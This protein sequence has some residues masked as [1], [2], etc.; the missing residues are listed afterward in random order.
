MTLTECAVA[1]GV[2]RY[3]LQMMSLILDQQDTSE[4]MNVPATA[5]NM[6]YYSKHDQ[7]S[8]AIKEGR[9]L[10][11]FLEQEKKFPPTYKYDPGSACYD[12]SEKM[13]LPAWTDRVFYSVYNHSVGARSGVQRQGNYRKVKGL[14][15][16]RLVKSRK[17]KKFPV[18]VL[19][20]STAE[21]RLVAEGSDQHTPTHT[22]DPCPPAL[23]PAE[24]MLDPV[25]GTYTS[26]PHVLHGDHRPVSCRFKLI[27]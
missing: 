25:P 24:P 14:H 18:S 11:G 12:T 27:V 2:L 17:Y 6:S 16:T 23:P 1:P 9:I 26:Y 7:C 15:T 3:I 8:L 10:K 19:T 21:G 20:N 5:L 22:A 4:N 13:R